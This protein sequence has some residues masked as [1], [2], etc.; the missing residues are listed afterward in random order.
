MISI[1]SNA[2]D[3]MLGLRAELQQ[4]NVA[5]ATRIQALLFKRLGFVDSYNAG[6][7][8]VRREEKRLRLKLAT[9]EQEAQS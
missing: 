3:M 1:N 9:T 8:Q 5:E 6:R 7:R 4:G 2:Y